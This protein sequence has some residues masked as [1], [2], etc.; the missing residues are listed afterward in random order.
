LGRSNCTGDQNGNRQAFFKHYF[1]RE[2]NEY[3]GWEYQEMVK[4]CINVKALS[5]NLDPLESFRQ[6]LPPRENL[7]TTD[8]AEMRQEA[9]RRARE[10]LHDRMMRGR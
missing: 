2:I 7:T 1:N 6:Y 4:E 5:G 3:A 10:A 9:Y 8:E